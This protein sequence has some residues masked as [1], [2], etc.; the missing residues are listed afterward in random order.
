M[1]QRGYNEQHVEKKTFQYGHPQAEQDGDHIQ[2]RL[3]VPGFATTA[4]HLG[5]DQAAA[6]IGED[7]AA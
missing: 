1:R 6:D 5:D 3:P 4:G 2:G 7:C